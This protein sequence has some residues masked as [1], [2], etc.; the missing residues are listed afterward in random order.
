M[1]LE[2]DNGL[3]FRTPRNNII[4]LL[5]KIGNKKRIGN[6]NK[7]YDNKKILKNQIK[8]IQKNWY[9]NK[10]YFCN[11]QQQITTG[12][13]GNMN[14]EKSIIKRILLKANNKI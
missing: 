2:T 4:K 13:P 7:S 6:N 14:N 12:I 9:W 8:F 5:R 1:G 3:S 11:L 10:K